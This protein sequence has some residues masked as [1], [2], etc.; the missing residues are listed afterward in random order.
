MHSKTT[1]SEMEK[2]NQLDVTNFNEL[3]QLVIAY[4]DSFSWKGQAVGISNA[5]QHEIHTKDSRSIWISLWWAHVPKEWELEELIRVVLAMHVTK[6]STSRWYSPIVLVKKWDCWGHVLT[7]QFGA[8]FLHI[9]GKQTSSPDVFP[10][11][12]RS[13]LLEVPTFTLMADSLRPMPW[14]FLF[15]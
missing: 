3:H 6:S 4:G 2:D 12:E 14:G 1:F 7:S 13:S 11:F 10:F 9:T 5:V 15:F 8:T